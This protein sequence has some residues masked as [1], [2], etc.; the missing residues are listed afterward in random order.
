MTQ[1]KSL[2]RKVILP[3][4]V[5]ATTVALGACVFAPYP[6]H[7]GGNRYGN[8]G[9]HPGYGGYQRGPGNAQQR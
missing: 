3:V 1:E 6:G 5:L 7:D 9:F 4:L 8:G 2:L